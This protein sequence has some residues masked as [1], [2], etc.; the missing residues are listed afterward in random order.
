[1]GETTL[2]KIK[3]RNSG[4]FVNVDE[5]S[6]SKIEEDQGVQEDKEATSS[7]DLTTTMSELEGKNQDAA[8]LQAE[9]DEL[10]GELQTYK[11]KLDELLS[12]EAVEAAAEG[13]NQSF[14]KCGDVV[15]Q[16]GAEFASLV[17]AFS[18]VQFIGTDQKVGILRASRDSD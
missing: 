15:V 8:A 5:E 16:R 1:M 4:K 17:Q 7:K 18:G 6:A 9:I 13:M 11:D 10:K 3:L 2:V 14:A 12:D